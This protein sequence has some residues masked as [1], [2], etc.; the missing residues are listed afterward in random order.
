MSDNDLFDELFKDDVEPNVDTKAALG[1]VQPLI[2]SWAELNETV[3]NKEAEL[4]ELK[5]NLRRLEYVDIPSAMQEVG[6][7]EIKTDDGLAVTCM[8]FV[9]G[10][11]NK[12]NAEQALAWLDDNG[13]GDLIKTKLE[14]ALGKGD[15][16]LAELAAKKIE[17]AIGVQPEVKETVHPQTMKSFLRQCE[18]DGVVL[19]EDLFRVYRGNVA[20]I[21]PI[22]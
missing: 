13:Y 7:A 4:K 17:A 8:P 15:K 22:K 11:I 10:G 21:K 14:L 3:K 12:Q 19:P 2:S 1:S 5:D 9:D 16:E 6:L 18:K 20:K